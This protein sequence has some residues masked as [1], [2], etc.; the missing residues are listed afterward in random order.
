MLIR[1]AQMDVFDRNAEVAFEAEMLDHLRNFLPFRA[2]GFEEGTLKQV[3]HDG[4]TTAR[5]HGFTCRGSL[6]LYLELTIVLGSAF[7]SDPQYPSLAEILSDSTNPNEMQ[8]AGRLYDQANAI[9]NQI[10]QPRRE[11]LPT[12]F[13]QIAQKHLDNLEE[14]D[15]EQF[16]I[17]TIADA[18]PEKA[19]H[20]DAAWL[21]ALFVEASQVTR[22]LHIHEPRGIALLTL[23]MFFAGH[24]VVRDAVYANQID[25]ALTGE[26]TPGARIEKLRQVVPAVLNCMLERQSSGGKGSKV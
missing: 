5:N 1:Q 9:L 22:V 16:V 24:G 11:L 6:R 19:L 15:L 7:D 3:V 18:Y 8:R 25:Q 20:T 21:H 23:I 4:L 14:Q 17:A 26:L 13:Q 2:Q 10:A 12:A